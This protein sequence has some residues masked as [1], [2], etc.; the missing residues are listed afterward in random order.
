MSFGI[1]YTKVKG[2]KT[3]LCKSVFFI[4]I[5][6]K[7]KSGKEQADRS[8]YERRDVRKEEKDYFRYHKR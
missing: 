4:T 1:E 3:L 7:E 2:R 8:I 6:L 5:D